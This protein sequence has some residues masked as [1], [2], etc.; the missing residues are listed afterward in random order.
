MPSERDIERLIRQVTDLV[1]AR[2]GTE[3]KD[4]ASNRRQ[5]RVLLPSPTD[6]LKTLA[7][8]LSSLE[9]SGYPTS[10]MVTAQVR[11]WMESV[12][13]MAGF[14]GHVQYAHEPWT[15]IEISLQANSHVLLLGSLGFAFCKRLLEFNDED[16]MVWM[17]TR[18]LL[19][20]VPVLAVR[21]DLE[22]APLAEA[23]ASVATK[24]LAILNDLQSMGIQV[25]GLDQM[26]EQIKNI[27]ISDGT[28]SRALGRLLTEADVERLASLGHK[29]IVLEKRTVITPLAKAKASELGLELK[30]S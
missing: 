12:G 8:V 17:T 3:T 2:M 1:L 23:T 28:L 30:E 24:G 16:P 18:A 5:I 6:N 7:R 21:D 19:Q 29:K 4:G 14:P 25:L 11:S 26:D 15:D 22:P 10:T 20:S 9:K 27:C 13:M